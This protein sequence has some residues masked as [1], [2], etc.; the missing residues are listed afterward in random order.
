MLLHAIGSGI[1]GDSE[2]L[3]GTSANFSMYLQEGLDGGGG[4]GTGGAVLWGGQQPLQ[5][6]RIYLILYQN[7]VLRLLNLHTDICS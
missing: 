6:I 1:T 4:G 2:Y 5:E 7:I 3:H